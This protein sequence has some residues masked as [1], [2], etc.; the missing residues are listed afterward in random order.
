MDI[1]NLFSS[2]LKG[3]AGGILIADEINGDRVILLGKSNIPNRKETYESFGGKYESQDLSSLH[4]ALRE[5]I[6]EFFNY[7]ISTEQI[8]YLAT[9]LK[10]SNHIIKQKEFYGMSYLINFN[11]LNFIFQ[12]LC[13]F[14]EP[15]N[16]YKLDNNFDLVKFINNRII[17]DEPSDGLN[18]IK[19]IDLLKLD[20]I[21]DKKIKLRWFTNK[22]IRLMV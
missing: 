6:E 15:L 1:G 8:N 17:I 16:N 21:S 9:E 13:L 20:D 22:I 5:F 7:K 10:K 12:K 14:I 19:S 18:E 2:D 3:K 4:T 11:G